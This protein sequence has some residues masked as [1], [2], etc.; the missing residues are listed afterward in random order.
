MKKQEK[1]SRQLKWQR[2]KISLGL[3]QICGEHA[4]TKVFCEKHRNKSKI[5]SHKWR[6]QHSEYQKEWHKK[7]PNYY[8]EYRKKMDDK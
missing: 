1:I 5:R 8:K 3:C 2:K 4:V 6:K 7:H